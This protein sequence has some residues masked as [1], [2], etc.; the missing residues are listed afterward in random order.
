MLEDVTYRQSVGLVVSVLTGLRPARVI[1]RVRGSG[2]K[3]W[4]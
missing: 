1:V 4:R 3:E 2:L